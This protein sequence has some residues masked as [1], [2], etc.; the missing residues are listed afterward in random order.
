MSRNQS[1]ALTQAIQSHLAGMPVW[2]FEIIEPAPVETDIDDCILN[3]DP[4]NDDAPLF[5]DIPDPCPDQRNPVGDHV[6]GGPNDRHCV[7]CGQ[8]SGLDR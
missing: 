6:F 7:Y 1:L 3:Y 2:A 5:C 8:R 4:R